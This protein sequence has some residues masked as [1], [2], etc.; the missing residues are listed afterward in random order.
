MFF[1]QNILFKGGIIILFV[2]LF[3]II[4]SHNGVVDYYHL[5]KEKQSVL[6]DNQKIEE[7][8]SKLSRQ[9]NRLKND[10]EYIEHVAKHEFGLAGT[11]ELVFRTITN[12]KS[13]AKNG[14]DQP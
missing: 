4:F 2:L 8:N 9:I 5:S 6:V 10:K 3:L 13:T 7:K 11:D 1:S 14:V 12:R